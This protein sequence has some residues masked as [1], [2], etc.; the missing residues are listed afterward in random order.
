MNIRTKKTR[1]LAILA[2]GGLLVASGVVVFMKVHSVRAAAQVNEAREAG[3]KAYRAG[4]YPVALKHLS[5]YLE[6]S[7]V[8]DR[9]PGTVD[10]D[11]LDALFA[12]G[13]SRSMVPM[14]PPAS[15]TQHAM[16]AVHIFER[17][18]AL[19][20]EPGLK[21]QTQHALLELYP[22][23]GYQKEALGLAKDVLDVDPDDKE[24]LRGRVQALVRQPTPQLA[25]ALAA[26]ERLTAKD[27]TDLRGQLQAQAIRLQMNT[28]PADLIAKA[29][30]L[31][32]KYPNDPRFEVLLGAT[33]LVLAQS[34]RGD[35]IQRERWGKD[36][37]DWL[38]K[39]A[40]RPPPDAEFVKQLVGA[41]DRYGLFGL[42]LDLLRRAVDAKEPG[43]SPEAAR[44]PQV[45]RMLVQRLFVNRLPAE[46]LARASA[47]DYNDPGAD[48]RVVGLRAMAQYQAAAVATARANLPQT[49]PADPGDAAAVVDPAAARAEA[50]RITKSLADRALDPAAQAWVV[51]LSTQFATPPKGPRERIDAFKQALGKDPDNAFAYFLMGDAYAALGEEANAA[52][53]FDAA[54]QRAPEWG[55]AHALVARARLNEGRAD[56]ALT[57]AVQAYQRSPRLRE[58]QAT[59]VLARFQSFGR[60]P[61]TADLNELAK[62]VADLHRQWPNDPETLPL[63]VT[64]LA[65]TGQ[66]PAAVERL[67]AAAKADP[68]LPPEALL[69][70]DAVARAEGLKDA[71]GG[72]LTGPLLTAAGGGAGAGAPAVA[73][74]R[75]VELLGQNRPDEGLSLLQAAQ[76]Q[77]K[78]AD[79]VNWR[80]AV[81]TYL[82]MAGDPA[83][84]KEWVELGEKNPADLGLQTSILGAAS[85]H[86]DRPFWARTIDR[87]KALTGEEGQL[88]RLERSRWLLTGDDPKGLGEAITT[89]TELVR[90]TPSN[91]EARRLLGLALAKDNK[92]PKAVEELTS[93]SNLRPDDID[94]TLDLVRAM[95]ASGDMKGSR[96]R[97]DQLSQRP[98]LPADARRKVAAYLDED[99]QPDRAIAVLTAGGRAAPA[100]S[101]SSTRPAAPA[102]ASRDAQRDGM[103]ARL[104]RRVGRTADAE[105]LYLKLLND[106]NAAPEDLS[107]GADFFGQQKNLPQAQK[108]LARLAS[109]KLRPGSLEVLLGRFDENYVSEAQ[110]AG[111]Y[112]KAAEQAPKVPGTWRALAGFH[113]RH[114]RFDDA[115]AALDKG[116]SAAGDDADLK[117]MKQRVATIRSF[118]KPQNVPGLGAL[119]DVVTRDPANPAAAQMLQVLADAQGAPGAAT[120]PPAD[121]AARLRALADQFPEFM[122]AQEQLVRYYLATGQ[123]DQAVAVADRAVQALAYDPEPARLL[124]QAQA[125]AG[126]WNKVLE[127]A[128]VWRQRSPADPLRADLAAADAHM[129]LAAPQSA[130]Q[131]LA[132]YVKASPTTRPGDDGKPALSDRDVTL[133]RVY[134]KALVAS[135]RAADAA[136]LLRPLLNQTADARLVW[137]DMAASHKDESAAVAW[138]DQVAPLVPADALEE[139]F[140]LASAWHAV[141]GSTA[142]AAAYGKARD[143]LRRLV[144]R[145]NV[146]ADG[147]D[148]LARNAL[149]LADY[150]DAVRGWQQAAK[151]G[152]R[153]DPPGLNNNLAYALLLRGK[154]EDLPEA[155]RLAKQA[156]D[157]SPSSSGYHD[158]LARIHSKLGRRPQAIA[159]F[160]AA[161]D[162][163]RDNVEPKVGLAAELARG[164]DKKDAE[165]ARGLLSEVNKAVGGR[166]ASTPPLSTPVRKQLESVRAALD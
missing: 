83:A 8:Q 155:E 21:L 56:E 65:R 121:T 55:V 165:E 135:G 12:Y 46:A 116:R 16:E 35:M 78:G 49:K 18:L 164:G 5:T 50:E 133:Y 125:A 9:A 43:A 7:K 98:E 159:E 58:V 64:L 92:L 143:L 2:L 110:A 73:L 163:D 60:N 66:R 41:L 97:V 148:L 119:I 25:E 87:V 52:A 131:R 75:A 71:A 94:T 48:V 62:V 86:L 102:V 154:A 126:K 29:D 37:Q 31:Y 54:A 84:L 39:A 152:G 122:P 80:R 69:K 144:D 82:E 13:K 158:T 53:M 117:A 32:K 127:A 3:M 100:T 19:S 27:P 139:Q 22:L 44:D 137:M 107:A 28:P 166:G 142:S 15:R 108:L 134:G 157:A 67:K 141:G 42:S 6:R 153:T 61:R 101:P 151:A 85:R 91:A 72:D 162:K 95:R 115:A 160:R 109:M 124:A 150:D 105:A 111:H 77:A 70:L 96:S 20:P 4:N 24:G 106:P 33:Y 129:A 146:S 130:V 36:A 63:Y 23:V 140:A 14:T 136:N 120:P 99:G 26:A 118:R 10:P 79:D 138:L 145:P 132:P 17:L 103:L 30:G 156:V 51:I 89:L 38:R 57:R 1:R 81:A 34:D 113:L 128:V 112:A 88:W 47:V 104:Y 76:W 147:W 93:A 45:V 40:K 11:A 90:Q 123:T 161:I 74:R 68:P 114:G 59:Y 149:E